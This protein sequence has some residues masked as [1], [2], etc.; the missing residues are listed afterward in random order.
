MVPKRHGLEVV[1]MG[2]HLPPFAMVHALPPAVS[3]LRV[4]TFAKGRAA[5]SISLSLSPSATK[6]RS[7][8][9]RLGISRFSIFEIFGCGLS[10]VVVMVCSNFFCVF[11]NLEGAQQRRSQKTR[12]RRNLRTRRG[13]SKPGHGRGEYNTDRERGY[14]GGRTPLWRTRRRGVVWCGVVLEN[15]PSLRSYARA[16]FFFFFF[17]FFP[18]REGGEEDRVLRARDGR[19]SGAPAR[20]FWTRNTR[21]RTATHGPLGPKTTAPPSLGMLARLH[22]QTH[23]THPPTPAPPLSQRTSGLMPSLACFICTDLLFCL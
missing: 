5:T 20:G 2:L 11:G 21:P 8:Y 10:S 13:R 22:G 15:P 16:T 17:F 18:T 9:F 7:R 4:V 6:K 1:F 3:I 23:D 14:R 19:A 12:E